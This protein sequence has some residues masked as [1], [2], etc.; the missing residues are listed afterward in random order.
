MKNPK[1]E[2]IR[3][4]PHRPLWQRNLP[5]QL[6]DQINGWK[7]SSDDDVRYYDGYVAL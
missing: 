2:F 6:K 4:S 1:E 5:L 3:M 7:E